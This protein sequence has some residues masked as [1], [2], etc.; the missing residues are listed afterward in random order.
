MGQGVYSQLELCF[1]WLELHQCWTSIDIIIKAACIWFDG[2][3]GRQDKI[4]VTQLLIHDEIIKTNYN[5]HM[6]GDTTL[7]IYWVNIWGY[8]SL[9]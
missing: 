3:C 2:L 6:R 8:F 5:H 1:L 4:S 7:I 9:V